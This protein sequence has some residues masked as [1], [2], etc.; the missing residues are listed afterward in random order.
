MSDKNGTNHAVITEQCVQNSVHSDDAHG[1]FR[2]LFG[3]ETREEAWE[4]V[5]REILLW[6]L[7]ALRGNP[8]DLH[9]IELLLRELDDPDMVVDV[10][11]MPPHCR[12]CGALVKSTSKGLGAPCE[13]TSSG[14]TC[15]SSCAV[16]GSNCEEHPRNFSAAK[17]PE[18]GTGSMYCEGYMGNKTS[19]DFYTCSN[20]FRSS[21]NVAHSPAMSFITHDSHYYNY[22][23]IPYGTAA[24]CYGPPFMESSCGRGSSCR[25]QV[26]ESDGDRKTSSDYFRIHAADRLIPADPNDRWPFE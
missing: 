17:S 25:F 6:V 21:G 24:E 15:I 9:M 3:C 20:S 18:R 1:S 5:V 14:P 8:F 23:D 4:Q 16:G 22:Y 7:G 13:E 10:N 12:S 11:V 2:E 26:L 19:S